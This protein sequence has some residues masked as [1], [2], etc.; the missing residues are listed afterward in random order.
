MVVQAPVITEE[1]IKLDDFT[2]LSVLCPNQMTDL[3]SDLNADLGCWRNIFIHAHPPMS[4]CI[5]AIRDIWALCWCPGFYFIFILFI[6]V[7]STRGKAA[8][9]ALAPCMQELP[10][11]PPSP[12]MCVEAHIL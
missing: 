9:K 2:P 12:P 1:P 3:H 4:V 7:L 5:V 11:Q 6:F 8:A 10:L